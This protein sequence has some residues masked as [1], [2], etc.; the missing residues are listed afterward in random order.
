MPNTLHFGRV[1]AQRIVVS[2]AARQREAAMPPEA[3]RGDPS[4]FYRRRILF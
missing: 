3:P 2:A 4:G 1:E